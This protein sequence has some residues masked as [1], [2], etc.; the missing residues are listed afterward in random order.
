ME[1]DEARNVLLEELMWVHDLIRTDLRACRHLAREV[2]RGADPIDIRAQLETLRSRGPLFQLRTNCL[3]HC[4]F[5]HGHH[6]HE[7]AML[8]PAVRKTAPV[9]GAVV[10]KLE[11]DHRK[12]SALLDVVEATAYEL[13][14]PE[15][16]PARRLLADALEELSTHLLDHLAYEEE[17]LAPVLRAWK[18]WPFY[19]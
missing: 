7:D 15:N 11:A 18:R 1:I 4:R 10:D 8:L 16:G 19:A 13:D 2:E 9:M 12:V 17:A 3:R 5:V 14:N 6:G